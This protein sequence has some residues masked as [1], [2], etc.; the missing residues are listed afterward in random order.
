MKFDNPA[1]H[2]ALVGVAAWF[3]LAAD[4]TVAVARIGVTGVARKA[5][6][7]SGSEA[8]LIGQLPTGPVVAEA[9]S[10]AVDDHAEEVNSDLHASSDYRAHLAR[11]LTRRALEAA[12][13][14]AEA[15]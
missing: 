10:H 11:V 5:Y 9:A 4:G 2:Y 3:Q 7:A 15:A 1:S 14:R 6:R 13:T 12:R 8:A